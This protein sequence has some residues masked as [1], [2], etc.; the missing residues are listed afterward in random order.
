MGIENGKRWVWGGCAKNGFGFKY[1]LGIGISILEPAA[2]PYVVFFF[3]F[4]DLIFEFES[5]KMFI[6]TMLLIL[7]NETIT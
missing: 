1:E 6:S 3:N 4:F 2:H 7:Q 5:F